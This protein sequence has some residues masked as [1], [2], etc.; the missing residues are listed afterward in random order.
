ML[1]V[2]DIMTGDVTVLAPETT[3]R[4][5]MDLLAQQH[6]SGAP[7]VSGN[8]VVG[9]VSTADLLAF[10]VSLGRLPVPSEGAP[11]VSRWDEASEGPDLDDEEEIEPFFAE[12][13]DDG[14]AELTARL[15]SEGMVEWDVL[16][17]HDVSEVMTRDLWTLPSDAPAKA[18]ADLMEEH[19]IHRILI[20]D[21]ETLVGIVSTLDIAKAVA[22]RKFTTRTY[23]FNRDG[24]FE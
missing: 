20:V 18:A 9:V 5:A 17:E 19:G 13:W 1:R 15:N 14:G 24:D 21:D 10:A 4:D 8:R 3:I 2:R 16:A 23:V 7:V 6:V 11:Q 22:A 12:L